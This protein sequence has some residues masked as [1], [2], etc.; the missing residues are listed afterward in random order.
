[1]A[2]VRDWLITFV[3]FLVIDMIWLGV[4]AR[5]FYQ[6]QVGHLLAERTNWAA[7]LL[8]YALYIVGMLF[9]VIHPALS[10]ASWREALFVGLAFG[11]VTYMTYD[12]TNLATLEGW[13][14]PLAVVDI[15]WGA[16]L[17]GSTSLVSYFLL[18]L[19][20]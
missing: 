14:L 9:F 13:P 4:I 7:A 15:L 11:A 6:N 8:F 5:D 20:R 17:G 1:M 18:R 12:L 2:W 16:F 3:V 10:Q 19:F